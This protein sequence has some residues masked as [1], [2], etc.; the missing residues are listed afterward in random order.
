MSHIGRCA[1]L[2]YLSVFDIHVNVLVSLLNWMFAFICYIHN[3][4]RVV[5]WQTCRMKQSNKQARQTI[6]CFVL[7]SHFIQPSEC[8]YVLFVCLSVRLQVSFIPLRFRNFGHRFISAHCQLIKII[9]RWRCRPRN[10]KSAKNNPYVLETKQRKFGDAK[11]PHYTVYNDN[12]R[13]L[14]NEYGD[15]SVMTAL[16]NTKK[17]KDYTIWGIFY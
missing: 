1:E 17:A 14:P 13:K 15:I 16:N 2:G 5:L 10:F 3:T 9:F 11:I 4:A 6:H 7:N 12:L 8:K